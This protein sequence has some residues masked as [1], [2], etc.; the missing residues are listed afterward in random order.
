MDSANIP[1][2]ARSGR[3]LAN[4]CGMLVALAM[5]ACAHGQITN[6]RL[7]DTAALSGKVSVVTVTSEGVV[8]ER[9]SVYERLDADRRIEEAI[10]SRL[11]EDDHFDESGD[12]RVSVRVTGFRLRSAGNAFWAGYMAGVDKLEGE[13]DIQQGEGHTNHYAFQLSG[14]EE[15]YFKYSATARFRSLSRELAEKISTLFEREDVAE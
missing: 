10:V 14:A 15:W 2:G 11:V 6:M 8:A 5:T 1:P 4:F 12:L 13:F 7:G 3:S 9:R